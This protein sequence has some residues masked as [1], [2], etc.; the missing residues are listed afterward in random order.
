MAGVREVPEVRR[1]A[2][3]ILIPLS[4]GYDSVAA[5]WKYR[6]HDLRVFH[7]LL[8]PGDNRMRAEHDSCRAVMDWMEG[9]FRAALRYSEIAVPVG[10]HWNHVEDL[11]PV[12]LYIGL[13]A[14]LEPDVE[15]IVRVA[16]A[17][18]LADDAYHDRRRACYELAD[19]LAGKSLHW[20]HPFADV[21]KIDVYRSLPDG[22]KERS[23]SCRNPVP[24][25]GPLGWAHCGKCEKCLECREAGIFP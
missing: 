20:Q 3:V 19:A 23:I 13:I 16:V 11:F 1:G 17:E 6:R 2:C 12:N 10:S 9:H 5:V 7:L 21:P 15:T 4:G 24:D 8:G 18:D 25:S 22:L 14:G